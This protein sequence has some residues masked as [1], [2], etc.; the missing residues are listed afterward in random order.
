MLT[1]TK[2]LKLERLQASSQDK[3]LVDLMIHI[4][5]FG[6]SIKWKINYRFYP[7]ALRFNM[8]TDDVVRILQNKRIRH[9]PRDTSLARWEKE[10]F[11]KFSCFQNFKF[12]DCV[13]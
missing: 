13:L 12:K 4:R 11:L 5:L 6:K 3:E 2:L 1:I 8:K 9:D 10:L 7:G